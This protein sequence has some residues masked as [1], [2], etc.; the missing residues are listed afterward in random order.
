M[1]E[2]YQD[3]FPSV[4]YNPNTNST[5]GEAYPKNKIG[6]AGSAD[7]PRNKRNTLKQK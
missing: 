4:N 6:S 2:E 3:N 5:S 7:D 1:A